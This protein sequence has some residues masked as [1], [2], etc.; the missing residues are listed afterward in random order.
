MLQEPQLPP[1]EL[2]RLRRVFL[3]MLVFEIPRDHRS[4]HLWQGFALS[5]TWGE[6]NRGSQ[7]RHEIDGF[8]R[9]VDY[10]VLPDARSHRH[11]PSSPGKCVTRSMM[12]EAVTAGIGVRITAEVRQ[13]EKVRFTRVLGV[14][15]DSL[16]DFQ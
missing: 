16:P 11:H 4:Q 14:A 13:D 2:P 9:S 1:C 8:Y 3:E 6:T 15:S 12:L 10:H 5:Q 7:C